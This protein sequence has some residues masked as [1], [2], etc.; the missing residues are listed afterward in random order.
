MFLRWMVRKDEQEADFGLWNGIP[1]SALMLSLDVHTGDVSRAL[2]LL[3]R[4]QNDW[5]AVEE[6]T[7]ILRTFD[8]GDPVKYDFALFGMG[9]KPTQPSQR[10][11]FR[12]VQ[13][14]KLKSIY[15]P[16]LGG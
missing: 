2:G 13:V 11:G 14:Y 12:L 4:K 3:E 15:I 6:I 8:A 16:P 5:R 1:A 7:G 9:L 10:E